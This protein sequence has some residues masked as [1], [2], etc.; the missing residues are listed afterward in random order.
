MKE[1]QIK[2]GLADKLSLEDISKKFDFDIDELKNELQSGTK[3]EMEHT[4]DKS[5]AKEIAMDHLAE[6]P[7][8]YTRL[9]KMEKDAKSFWSNKE[10]KESFKRKVFKKLIK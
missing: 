8:Y 4:D 10:L 1:D 5:K 6:M 9:E 3:V 2:G 7:D